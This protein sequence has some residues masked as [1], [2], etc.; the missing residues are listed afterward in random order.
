[1]SLYN[2]YRPK[3]FNDVVGQ[4]FIIT[5]ILNSIKNDNLPHSI[6]LIGKHGVG[7]TTIARLIAKEMDVHKN[8]I[9]EIDAASR[10]SKENILEISKQSRAFPLNSDKKIFI[11]DECHM[12]SKSAFNSFLKLLEEPPDHVLF[13]LCTTELAEIPATIQS[14]CQL[15]QLKNISYKDIYERLELIC[16]KEKIITDVTVL[17][18]IVINAD[19]SLRDAIS[20]LEKF[21]S[22]SNGN[23]SKENLLRSLGII[24]LYDLQELLKTYV[25][26]SNSNM[27]LQLNKLLDKTNYEKFIF[28]FS[29]YIRS[30]FQF[31]DDSLLILIDYISDAQKDVLREYYKSLGASLLFYFLNKLA[32]LDINIKE[33]YNKRLLVELTMIDVMVKRKKIIKSSKNNKQ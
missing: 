19:G 2:K 22:Y 6:L 24:S 32:E 8:D 21:I 7:K 33:S 12:L 14:R 28:Q 9:H 10:N 27:L 30:I 11:I 4:E 3:E 20:E 5:T 17:N 25:E 1:M 16:K 15:H 31:R 23:L 18:H 29:D 13:F 26:G